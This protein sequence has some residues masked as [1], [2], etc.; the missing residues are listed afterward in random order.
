MGFNPQTGQHAPP[1]RHRIQE[2]GRRPALRVKLANMRGKSSDLKTENLMAPFSL[3]EGRDRA[4]VCNPLSKA[5]MANY[6]AD[7]GGVSGQRIFASG[8]AE[9]FAGRFF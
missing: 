6:L 7:G 1:P 8:I 9:V 3:I 2:P 5:M 4:I